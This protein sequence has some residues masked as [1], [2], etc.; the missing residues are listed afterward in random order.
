MLRKNNRVF[1][2]VSLNIRRYVYRF[3]PVLIL[4][5]ASFAGGGN[6]DIVTTKHNFSTSGPPSLFKSL[7]E[8]RICI[9]C[10]VPHNATPNTPL[11]SKELPTTFYDLYTSGTLKAGMTQPTGPTKLCL[12]CHDGT[13]AVGAVILNPTLTGGD[14]N[15]GANVKL[16]SS[17]T[18]TYFGNNLLN[19]HPV[20]FPYSESFPNEELVLP[21]N[22]PSVITL[23]GTA[24]EVH[25]TSC[26]NPH[27]DAY[28]HFLVA[29]NKDSAI[30]TACHKMNG[31][32]FSGHAGVTTCGSCHTPHFAL[33][34]PLLT[35]ASS[36]PVGTTM[37]NSA[38]VAKVN[39]NSADSSFCTTVCH[40]GTT[41]GLYFVAGAKTSASALSVGKVFSPA[42][43]A[44]IRS[45][46]MKIS[47]HRDV[48]GVSREVFR[49]NTGEAWSVSQ[50]GCTACHNPHS[51]KREGATA[52]NASGMLA[53][54]SGIDRNGVRVASVNYEYEVCFKCH[55]DKSISFMFVPRVINTINMRL[56]FDT[57][58]PSYHPVVGIGKNFNVPSIPS[59]L[60]PNL[61][62][63]A[64]IYCTDCHKDN[65][66]GSRG[67]HGSSIRPILGETYQTA[68]GTPESYQNYALCY[69][70]HS[71]DSIL[72]DQSFMKNSNGK[73]GHSGHLAKGAPC[74]AC[75]DPHGVNVSSSGD[76]GDHTHLINFNTMIV[77]PKPGNVYPIFKS[78]GVFSGNC[79]L[80]CHGKLHDNES[81]P[82]G[83]ISSQGLRGKRRGR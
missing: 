24:G 73:G 83:G 82:Q 43:G 3:I 60:N 46:I 27:D 70:C 5:W 25:C 67:P 78:N 59:Q 80:V 33:A 39:L 9:F 54:V 23:G 4:F 26:H 56:A 13:I 47:S 8:T 49:D 31:W 29:D 77:T 65:D 18:T 11:W 75:H 30:C 55:G 71:R 52:P 16:S 42:G 7:S 17:N 34:E 69:R 48:V 15:L 41:E 32:V 35:T 45:Q 28:G 51:A 44:D 76:T 36:Q 57:A 53:G 74:S 63:M 68:D 21:E 14:P 62:A 61:N 10:H 40:G 81:Y 20:S 79:T 66:G 19:H 22:L 37:T 6:S 1:I 50:A 72:Q 2:K 38:R 64:I 58:N 12:S